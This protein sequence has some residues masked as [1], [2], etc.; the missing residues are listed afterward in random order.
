MKAVVLAGGKGTRLRPYTTVFPKPMVPVGDHPILEIILRKLAR[1]GFREVTL[2]VGYLSQLIRAYFDQV[3][4]GLETL[5][6]SYVLEKNPTGTAGALRLIPNLDETFLMMNGDL[7]TTLPF[8]ELID[9]H[10][11][12]GAILTIATHPKEVNIDLGVLE[13][14]D[15]DRITAYTEKPT[16]RYR[17]SMGVYVVEPAAVQ[18]VPE[19]EYFD[20]PTLV[21]TLLDAKQPVVGYRSD[22]YWLDIGRHEDYEEAQESFQKMRGAFGLE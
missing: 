5:D 20:F 1:E 22:H 14:D 2:S 6:I 15:D 13:S 8:P 7:L 18:Y 3:H 12:K 16:L 4:D 19:N 21:Q 17:V 11:K 9:Y 10:R